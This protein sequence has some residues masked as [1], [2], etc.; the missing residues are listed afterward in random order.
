MQRDGSSADVVERTPADTP[1]LADHGYVRFR[2]GA[3]YHAANPQVVKALQQAAR[4]GTRDDYR[5]YA[6]LV[7][8]RPATAIRDLLTSGGAHR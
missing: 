3:E 6:E 1:R 5:R 2:R 7:Y 8:S 4:S